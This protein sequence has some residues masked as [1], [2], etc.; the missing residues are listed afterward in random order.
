MSQ[1]LEGRFPSFGDIYQVVRDDELYSAY[2]VVEMHEGEIVLGNGLSVH[3]T[4]LNDTT[5]WKYIR[6]I[7]EN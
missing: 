7:A 4:D 2:M 5:R 6:N 1:F 3:W